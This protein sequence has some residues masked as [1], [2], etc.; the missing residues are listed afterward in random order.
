MLFLTHICYCLYVC[1]ITF[2][3]FVIIVKSK[4]PE[5]RPRGLGIT[6]KLAGLLFLCL[7]TTLQSCSITLFN[8]TEHW[9]ILAGIP[10]LLV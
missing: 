2:I 7:P 6:N 10:F 4:N 9:G 8:S 3:P 1:V 5:L